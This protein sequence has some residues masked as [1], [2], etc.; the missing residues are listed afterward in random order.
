MK[1]GDLVKM[2]YVSFWK[3]KNSRFGAPYTQVP[4][5]VYET[6]HNAI[7][8]IWPDGSI[9]SDLVENYEVVNESR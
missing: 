2:K 7:K 9:K 5:L 8:V 1:S 6:S 4:L 3:K